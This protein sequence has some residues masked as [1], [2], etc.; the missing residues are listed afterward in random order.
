MCAGDALSM[1][2]ALQ[3]T[4]FGCSVKC[5]DAAAINVAE[6]ARH[7]RSSEMDKRVGYEKT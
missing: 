7:L 1:P 5:R 6:L 2:E 4:V 3:R